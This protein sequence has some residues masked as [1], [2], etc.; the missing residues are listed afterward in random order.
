MCNYISEKP[1]SPITDF[2]YKI[3]M[4]DDKNELS[5]LPTQFFSDNDCNLQYQYNILLNDSQQLQMER[6]NKK[7]EK[8]KLEQKLDRVKQKQEERDLLKQQF[9]I[10]RVI[11]QLI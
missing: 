11:F 6:K 1:E 3:S 8:R 7:Q 9:D 2:L 5:S 10:Y 4:D